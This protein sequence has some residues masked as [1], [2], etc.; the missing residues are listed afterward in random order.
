M[1]VRKLTGQ[2]ILDYGQA[3][4]MTDNG[5]LRG[6]ISDGTYIFRGIKYAD[7]ERFHMPRPVEP[8]KGVKEAIVYGFACPEITTVIPHDQ[9]TVPHYFTVQS[10]DCQYLNIWTGSINSNE[11][12]PVMVWLHGGG[13]STGSGVEHYA[14][15]GENLSKSGDVV[16]VTL[17]HRLNVLG[18]LDM[19]AYGEEYKYS[20]NVGIADIVA[21]LQWIKT[22]I[23]AFGGDP[24]NVTIFGQSGGAGKVVTLINTPCAD[25]LFHKAIM[26]SGGMRHEED[27][28]PEFSRKVAEYVMEY[29]GFAPEEA[30]K[31]E[32]VSFDE[33]S[34]AA[35]YAEDKIRALT[36]KHS[37]WFPV[38]DDDFFIGHPFNVGFRKG[39]ENIPLMCGSVMGEFMQNYTRPRGTGNKNTWTDEY[40]Y[41]M[42]EEQFGD[43]TD[44]VISAF[45]KAYPGKKPQDVLF[46]DSQGRKGA[47]DMAALHSEFTDAGSYNFIFTWESKF[48]GGTIPWHNS[49]IPYIFRNADYLEPSYTPGETEKLMDEVSGAWVSF[50]RTGDP[51]CECLPKWE[52][53][54]KDVNYAM[55]FDVDTRLG[56]DHDKELMSFLPDKAPSFT[57]LFKGSNV[58]EEKK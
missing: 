23:S 2:V 56:T 17:N 14:Y 1:Y 25:G 8:W 57:D 6:V 52:E 49:E 39:S 18:H 21:A 50:A 3:E 42:I 45:K 11:K 12:K 20:G 55:I 36:K 31:L 5:I 34:L 38:K 47:I 35:K 37:V 16:V 51:N 26:Q 58:P 54:T 28:T 40:A 33:L 32:T 4:V 53:C 43:K 13:F 29:F 10:E 15:D 22:N 7:A 30:K 24:D 19:S 46:M 48:N 41:K 27:T 44:A 9:F